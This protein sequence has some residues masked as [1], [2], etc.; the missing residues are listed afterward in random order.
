MNENRWA[1]LPLVAAAA[2]ALIVL[3]AP[4]DVLISNMPDDVFYYLKTAQVYAQ[5]GLSSFDGVNPSNGYQPLWFVVSVVAAKIFGGGEPLIRFVLTISAL[6]SALAFLVYFR[7]VQRVTNAALA[8]VAAALALLFVRTMMNGLES[9]LYMLM[10]AW[11]LLEWYRLYVTPSAE[12][13]RGDAVRAGLVFGVCFLARTDFALILIPMGLALWAKR[14]RDTRSAVAGLVSLIPL[15]VPLAVIVG[16]YLLSNQVWFGHMMPVSGAAKVFHSSLEWNAAIAQ[17]GWLGAH[18]DN[19]S[20]I[21]AERGFCFVAVSLLLPLINVVL[22]MSQKVDDRTRRATNASAIVAAG[23]ALVIA[24]YVTRFHGGFTRTFWYYGPSAMVA[25]LALAQFGLLLERRFGLR[26]VPAALVTVGGLAWTLGWPGAALGDKQWYFW[27][28]L[29]V[30]AVASQ[31][32]RRAV[33]L[34]AG[35]LALVAAVAWAVST[36][37]VV[38][39]L[40]GWTVAVIVAAA[41]SVLLSVSRRIPVTT[42][43]TTFAATV[44]VC[45]ATIHGVNLRNEA[46][47]QPGGWNYALLLGARWADKNLPPDAT[48]WSGSA[49][50]LGYFSGRTVTNTDGLINSYDFLDNTLKAGKLWEYQQQRQYAIDAF[51]DEGLKAVFPG[52]CFIELPQLGQAPFEDGVSTRLL[53]VYQMHPKGIKDC[54]AP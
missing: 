38:L 27:L 15:G 19:V 13:R 18:L 40:A 32:Q 16:G 11:S 10:F 30:L 12:L 43:A 47:S 42:L 14:G 31:T 52:G 2:L 35:A 23:V 9:A 54:A 33:G 1:A 51:P 41:V 48:I 50:I 5:T 8:M 21:F 20:W 53:G 6:A 36:D 28:L 7:A 22:A 39:S 4:L 3:S 44:L 34:A 25:G 37:V 26:P 24:F 46:V 49:G 17:K 29:M 45:V